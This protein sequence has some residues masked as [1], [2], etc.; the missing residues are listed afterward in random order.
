VGASRALQD[1]ALALWQATAEPARHG[2]ALPD[3]DMSQLVAA[4]ASPRG[5]SMLLRAARVA[6][7]LDGRSSVTPEDIQSVFVPATAHRLVLQ[8]VY[9]LRRH[10]IAP[11]LIDAILGR[12]AAP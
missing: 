6:A 1:Y 10:E 4:G 9:E 11:Q 8:P 12:V 3:V 7:W 5:M 2:V